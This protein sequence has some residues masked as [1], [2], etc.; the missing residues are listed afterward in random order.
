MVLM[1][2]LLVLWCCGTV[3]T[4]LPSVAMCTGPHVIDLMDWGMEGF[5]HGTSIVDMHAG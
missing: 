2:A 5:L 3:Y 4:S 1:L